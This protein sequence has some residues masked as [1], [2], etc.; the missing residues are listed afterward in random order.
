MAKSLLWRIEAKLA[1]SIH[2]LKTPIGRLR[3]TALIEA[4]SFLV[5]LGIA[6]PLKYLAGIPLA[7]KIVGWIHGVLFI[8]FCI[9]LFQAMRAHS[10]PFS[11]AALVFVAALLPF[12]PFVIDARLRRE[13]AA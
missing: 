2:V 8:A 9:A 6:M 13:D 11:R 10:W 1:V 7:V 12:G 3:A 5:L 4:T